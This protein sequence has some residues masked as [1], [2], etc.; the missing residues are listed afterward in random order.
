[1]APTSDERREVAERLR[2]EGEIWNSSW[3]DPDSYYNRI[4]RCLGNHSLTFE[5]L[6]DLIEPQ[7]RT[8]HDASKNDVEFL[9]SNCHAYTE[10]PNSYRV[11]IGY[12][13]GHN[14]LNYCPYCGSRVVTNNGE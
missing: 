3:Q 10:V 6:A 1:M 12:K 8:C 7:Q 4:S 11:E 5:G 9:C 14:N 13:S 2:E